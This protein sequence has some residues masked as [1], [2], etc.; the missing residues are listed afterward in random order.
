M[1]WLNTL[2]YT[3]LGLITAKDAFD[4][5]CSKSARW[6]IGEKI[7]PVYQFQLFAYVCLIAHQA[8]T[9]YTGL[10]D[11]RIV[12]CRLQIATLSGVDYVERR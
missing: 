3:P 9:I 8:P 11:Q 6:P 12:T 5:R 7:E 2:P 1:R 4:P 10:A